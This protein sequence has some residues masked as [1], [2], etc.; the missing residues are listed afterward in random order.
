MATLGRSTPDPVLLSLRPPSR[1]PLARL[2]ARVVIAAL[3]AG[4][5]PPAPAPA[6]V[7]TVGMGVALPAFLR[8]LRG[9]RRCRWPP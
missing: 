9:P 3:I 4:L 7:V 5:L 8:C 6:A 1:R 2:T